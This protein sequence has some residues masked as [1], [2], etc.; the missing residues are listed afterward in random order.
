MI[1]RRDTTA[2]SSI[3]LKFIPRSLHTRTHIRPLSLSELRM[4]FYTDVQDLSYLLPML[5]NQISEKFR[6][7]NKAIIELIEDFNL[8]GFESLCV[9]VRDRSLDGVRMKDC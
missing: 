4:E 7:L 6:N 1:V 9:E 3:T 2:H 8:V 5:E